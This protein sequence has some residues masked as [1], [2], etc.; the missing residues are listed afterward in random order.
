MKKIVLL[1]FILTTVSFCTASQ[2]ENKPDNLYYVEISISRCRLYLYQVSEEEKLV[3]VKEYPVGTVKKGI[4]EYPKGRGIVTKIELNPWWYPTKK[5]IKE[6]AKRGII[7]PESV[8][9]GHPLN[10]MGSFKIHLS[11][12]V[13][14]KGAI[15]R[16]HGS[17]K[18]D[19]N[20]IGQRVSGG[21]VRMYNS[22]GEEMIKL[23]SVGTVVNIIP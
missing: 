13:P 16:I 15:Y 6:F 5:T 12:S 7:L 23:I 8:P 19:E 9:P 14:G 10:F 2:A 21:C 3:I 18:Q 1:L 4:R 22:D 11:H 17:R 20:K